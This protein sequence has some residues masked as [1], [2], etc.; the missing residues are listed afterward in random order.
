MLPQEPS[1]L[2]LRDDLTGAWNRRYLRRLLDEDWASVVAAQ[3]TITLLVLDLDFFKEI[4]DA[5][6]HLAGDHVLQQAT[7]QLRASFRAEDRLIRYGGDEFVVALFGA[8]AAEARLLAERARAVLATVEV[9]ATE[10]GPTITLPLSFSMGVATFPADGDSGE[11]ILAVA[12]RRL[13]EEKRARRPPASVANRGRRRLL[14]ASG[15]ALVVFALAGWIEWRRLH[16]APPPPPAAATLAQPADEPAPLA[17]IVVRDEEELARLREEVQRLQAELA[18]ARP[19][20]DRGRYEERIRELE[21]RL[22]EAGDESAQ[23]V[24]SAGRS[25]QEA[26]ADGAARVADGVGGMQIGERR[27]REGLELSPPAAV[28]AEGAP[29]GDAAGAAH[30]AAAAAPGAEARVEPPQLVRALRPDYPPVARARR[31]MAT[32]ELKLRVDA[33][34]KVIAVEPVGPPAGLGFDESAREAALSAQFRPGRRDGV[35]VEMETRL[36][37]RFLLE[38]PPR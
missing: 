28:A 13:Y 5:H 7:D 16:R 3:E 36:A 29:P 31:R 35:A 23:S 37:I 30:R 15:L 21:T 12:D 10:G 19:A 14:L 27:L 17:E 9:T 32:V 26:D 24:G 20:D 22:T 4:N 25:A 11:E 18:Q 1:D 8:G 33:A 2:A 38:G 6:G 34:G